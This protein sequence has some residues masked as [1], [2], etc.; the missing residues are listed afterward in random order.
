MKPQQLRQVTLYS[1]ALLFVRLRV[2]I[3]RPVGVQTALLFFFHVAILTYSY[4]V[5]HRRLDPHVLHQ[6]LPCRIAR[7]LQ[8]LCVIRPIS[9]PQYEGCTNSM[10]CAAYM[11]R[12]F[13]E[14]TRLDSVHDR[15][16]V[17]S[18]Q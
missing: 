3:L 18:E 17:F 12:P 2:R 6:L 5:L 15:Y 8:R 10:W 14:R 16:Q 4:E 11:K 9:N 13:G 1:Q 7:V